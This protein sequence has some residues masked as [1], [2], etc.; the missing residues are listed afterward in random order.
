MSGLKNIRGRR[1]PAQADL[2]RRW[3]VIF[4]DHVIALRW[5]STGQTLAA[6]AISG[7]ISILDSISGTVQHV[8]PGH[9]GLGTT[10]LDWHPDGIRLASSGQDGQVRMWDTASGQEQQ[11]LAV[12]AA[13]VER[14]AWHPAGDLLAAAGGRSVRLWATDGTL[15][16]TWDTHASTVADIAWEP[17]G[18][19]LATAAYGGVT[20]WQPGQTELLRRYQ[21]QGS[22][23][24]LAWSPDGN[25]IATGDQDS[26][27]H[28][29]YVASG[30]DLQMWG[31]ETKVLELAWHHSSRY[32]ATGGGSIPCVWDCQA[33]ANG[34]EGSHPVQL[35]AHS[36]PVTALAY[37]HWGD[38]LA[39]GGQDGGVALWEPQRHNRRYAWAAGT[40]AVTRLAWSPDD[41]RLAVGY[42]DGTVAVYSI[43]PEVARVPRGKPRRT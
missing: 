24:V 20:L 29:W 36:A 21:W 16:H 34:P 13:W 6:A 39:S 5:S 30:T 17:N 22:T 25:L 35:T 28:F 4:D 19:H 14:V 43:T 32:L 11:A 8:L 27:V 26:T 9:P 3:Q 38:L 18:T 42:D 23:L 33:S 40:S 1:V 2:R 41:T 12:G 15:R 10:D 37:Q 31:Y 7:P